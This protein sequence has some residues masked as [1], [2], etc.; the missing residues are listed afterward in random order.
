MSSELWKLSF[1]E[2]INILESMKQD[3]F[4]ATYD[5]NL[6]VRGS[7]DG[8]EVLPALRNGFSNAEDSFVFSLDK[9]TKS[10]IFS[11][12]IDKEHAIYNENEFGPE[13][14]DGKADLGL[15]NPI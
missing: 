7:R 3:K 9:N 2:Y 1:E 12:V 6:L 11:K 5:F 10:F 8:F 15:F 4:I 14:G 13:F